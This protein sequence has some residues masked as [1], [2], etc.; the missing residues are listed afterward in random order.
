MKFSV[1]NVPLGSSDLRL[2]KE[3]GDDTEDDGSLFDSFDEAKEKLMSWLDGL[4]DDVEDAINLLD[5]A[6]SVDD[7]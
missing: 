5:D 3:V 4:R 1:V 7:L 2:I 6:D